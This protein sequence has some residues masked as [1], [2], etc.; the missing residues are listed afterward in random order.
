MTDQRIYWIPARIRKGAGNW[1]VGSSPLGFPTGIPAG[2]HVWRVVTQLGLVNPLGLPG[3][4]SKR[5]LPDIEWNSRWEVP[6]CGLRLGSGVA[7]A[8]D[9][10]SAG[11]HCSA[12]EGTGRHPWG[13][14]PAQW[15]NCWR[16][17]R[18]SWIGAK[19]NPP[20]SWSV[21][22][23]GVASPATRPG[24]CVPH[25]PIRRIRLKCDG[26]FNLAPDQHFRLEFRNSDLTFAAVWHD[27][28]SMKNCVWTVRIN[29]QLKRFL[30]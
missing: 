19:S 8:W 24:K 20:Q 29:S 21:K 12:G 22:M 13:C 2:L 25:V 10:W 9:G 23:R 30:I 27:V 18:K 6:H 17:P 28:W 16:I 1:R 11:E 26:L 4:D 5:M 7:W 3:P 15:R 14:F